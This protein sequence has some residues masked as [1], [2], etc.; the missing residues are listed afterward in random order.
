MPREKD[1]G[2]DQT[3]RETIFEQRKEPP[4][5]LP[6]EG[7][8]KPFSIYTEAFQQADFGSICVTVRS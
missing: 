7:A 6:F 3:Q 5:F 2:P 4:K 1:S 8:N